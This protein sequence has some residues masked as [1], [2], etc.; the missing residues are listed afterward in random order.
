MIT[1]LKRKIQE[2]RAKVVVVGQGYVGLPLAMAAADAG[3][4]VVGLEKSLDRVAMLEAGLSYIGDVDN[5]TLQNALRNGYQPTSDVDPC[6]DFD[7]AVISVPTPL[8]HGVPDLS[9]VEDAATTLA[10][11][12]RPGACVILESTTFPGTTEELV[13]PLLLDGSGLSQ[14]SIF[15]GY[16][17][18]R[19]DPG[20]ISYD[21]QSTPKIIS[22]IN[23]ASFSV[24]EAFFK[25]LGV[26]TV[27][28]NSCKEAEMAKL[29]ENTFRHVNIALVNELARFAHQLDINI[30]N[31]IEAAG[32]KPFGF[33]RFSPGPGVGGHCL[34]VD[35]SYLA[36]KVNEKLG[37]TFRFIEL[38]NDINDHMPDYVTNRLERLLNEN[39][40]SLGT[41][42][43][44][45]L[46]LAYKEDTSDWRESPSLALVDRLKVK[47]ASVRVCDPLVAPPLTGSIGPLMVDF[48]AHQLRSADL[49]VLMVGHTAFTKNLI[50]RE[51]KLV[52]DARNI[53][54]DFDFMGE[55]L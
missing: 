4:P 43:V 34:P 46:G 26:E 27:S 25:S 31:V 14:D 9:F 16:S 7:L 44:L 47:G 17:P 49:V 23:S 3:F 13:L 6:E 32:T 37:E 21:F 18:E 41:S 8:S 55:H 36:W 2:R 45:V 51:S 54:Q 28:V 11:V 38:A 15:L 35:P 40:K 12:L 52:F 53:L 42:E 5:G 19:I 50:A 48:S 33:M 29:L 22:G 1:A 30:W 20:N 39:G 24:I 10:R